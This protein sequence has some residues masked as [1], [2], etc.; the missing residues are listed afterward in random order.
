M[1]T[2]IELLRAAGG[3]RSMFGR[4]GRWR[5]YV[6]KQLDTLISGSGGGSCCILNVA[7]GNG[8]VSQFVPFPAGCLQPDTNYIVTGVMQGGILTQFAIPAK[9]TIGFQVAFAGVTA[10]GIV[11]DFKVDRC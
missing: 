5:A 8:Q 9:A 4:I 2:A 7:I 3:E 10:G 1:A 6:S 11:M